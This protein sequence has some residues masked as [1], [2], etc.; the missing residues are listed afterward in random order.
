MEFGHRA[1]TL[2]F[3]FASGLEIGHNCGICFSIIL[4][5]GY[6]GQGL[7]VVYTLALPFQIGPDVASAYFGTF[8]L[9][10]MFIFACGLSNF[11]H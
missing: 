1:L 7:K 8:W 2:A 4:F 10:F 9:W 6:F 3:V 11:G 5:S